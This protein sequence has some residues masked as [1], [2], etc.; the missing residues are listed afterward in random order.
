[1]VATDTTRE[2]L[3]F[4]EAYALEKNIDSRAHVVRISEVEK[5]IASSGT[6]TLSFEE[7]EH[8]ARMAWRNNARCIGRLF[9]PSLKVRDL[10]HI[11]DPVEVHPAL[12]S[13]LETATNGGKIQPLI[14]VFAPAT[15]EGPAVRIWNHQLLGYAG[16][17]QPDGSILGDPKNLSFTREALSLG[18]KG[19]DTRFDLLPL[20]IQ[21]RGRAP[22]LFPPPHG[23]ALEIPLRHPTWPWVS[24]LGLKWYAVPVLS[25]MKLRIGGIDFPAAPFNGWYMGTE[26]GSRDLGDEARYN[27]LPAIAEKMGINRASDPLWKDRA[28]VELNA[29]VIFSYGQDG[30]RIVDHHRASSEFMEFA[31]REMK[32]GRAVSADWSWIVPPM[33][34]SATPVFHQLWENRSQVPDYLP[35]SRAWKAF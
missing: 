34:S 27:M 10:R 28:L 21:Q 26:I 20:I 9:W 19:P 14:T 11:S 8:G 1:M 17:E 29:A 31:A 35:Q 12:L 22:V 3:D 7:L 2:A 30:V 15:S 6:W 32:A 25:D 13:H 16:Y 24:D 18:W 4:L 33:S 23:Q 5:E